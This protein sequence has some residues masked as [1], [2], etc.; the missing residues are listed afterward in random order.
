VYVATGDGP[1][2][3]PVRALR[4]FTK[5]HLEPGEARTVSFDLDRRAFAYWDVEQP[6]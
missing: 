6:G 2:R 5:V 3:R 4:A 1:V